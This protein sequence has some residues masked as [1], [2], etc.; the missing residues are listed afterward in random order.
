VDG[1]QNYNV[2]LELNGHYTMLG[3]CPLLFMV[4]KRQVL[5]SASLGIMIR[6]FKNQVAAEGESVYN[7]N[8]G[9]SLSGK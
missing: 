6:N 3:E 8:H 9:K 1:K 2:T 4:R 7:K 5:C